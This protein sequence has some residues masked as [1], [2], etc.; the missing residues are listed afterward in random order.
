MSQ[1]FLDHIASSFEQCP[2]NLAVK[3]GEQEYSY[4]QFSSDTYAV[5]NDILSQNEKLTGVLTLNHPSTY[6]ALIGNWFAGSAYVPIPLEYPKERLAQIIEQSEINTIYAASESNELEKLKEWFPQIKWKVISALEH[7]QK[8]VPSFQP[9]QV[10]YLLFTSGTT[11]KP[12]GVPITHANLQNFFQAFQA[13]KYELGSQDRFL[14]MFELTFDLSVMSFMIPLTLGA[15][16]YPLPSGMIRTLGLYHVLEEEQISFALMV[17]SA[18]Q[19]L[20]PYLD[21]IHLPQMKYSQFCGEALKT[22]LVLAWSKCIPNARIDNVYG[23][24]EATIY[25]SSLTLEIDRLSTHQS[26]MGVVGIG[27]AMQGMKMTIFSEENIEQGFHQP[28]E[29]CLSGGQ[30]TPGYWN[31]EAQ[32]QK[33][34]FEIAGK[35]YYRTGDLAY[36]DEAGQYFYLGRIDDQVKI[37]GFRVELAEL[38]MA[39][40]AA[41]PHCTPVA[42]GYQDE[43]GTWFLALFIKDLRIPEK[44]VLEALKM[45]LPSYMQPSKLIA[46][47]EI[48]LNSNGKTDRKALKQRIQ[49]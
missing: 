6:T 13:L 14:Q 2:S 20:K 8:V 32:N 12:K 23:P 36:A 19:L 46:I 38:E 11:G 40:I 39:A 9:H 44:E 15:S 7:R 30:L 33:S 43:Q 42:V 18:I 21:D 24:T 25:C 31:N 5:A 35:R 1:T 28:G 27:K 29:L 48:P 16:F 26:K 3:S 45:Q 49:S 17:P 47:D 37:Q 4:A 41:D 10:A 22:D 34:F